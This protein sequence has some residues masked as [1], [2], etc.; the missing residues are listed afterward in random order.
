MLD[1]EHCQCS[2]KDKEWEIADVNGGVF[3]YTS[4]LDY[5]L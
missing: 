3:F 1:L 2:F 5:F 4:K